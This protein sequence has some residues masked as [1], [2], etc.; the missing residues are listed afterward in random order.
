ML[1]T[2]YSTH[3]STFIQLQ[4]KLNDSSTGF[5]SHAST[6]N[7]H[8]QCFHLLRLSW[9]FNCIQLLCQLKFS[10]TTPLS[11]LLQLKTAHDLSD[12]ISPDFNCFQ[13]WRLNWHL[14]SFQGTH[15]NFLALN[16]HLNPSFSSN[17]SSTAFISLHFNWWFDRFLFPQV[18]SVAFISYTHAYSLT[19]FIFYSSTVDSDTFSAY[20]LQLIFL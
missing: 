3:G 13:L 1:T 9:Q 15:L 11:T 12:Y 19:A 17:D 18:M 10:L 4:F 14:G 8:F 7:W 16:G 2:I 20:K 6:D 5:I